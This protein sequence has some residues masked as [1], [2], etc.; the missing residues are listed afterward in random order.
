MCKHGGPPSRHD[1]QSRWRRSALSVLPGAALFGATS[2]VKR[3]VNRLPS[4]RAEP[5]PFRHRG[6]A[7]G[8]HGAPLHDRVHLPTYLQDVQP[9]PAQ[10]EPEEAVQPARCEEV[11]DGPMTEAQCPRI[12]PRLRQIAFPV[13]TLT[14][15]GTRGITAM[16]AKPGLF[17]VDGGVVER[18]CRHLHAPLSS[19]F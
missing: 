19:R 10:G 18:K 2:Q 13:V 9:H 8:N 17:R 7:T 15:G 16:Y 3:E 14:W 1:K 4:S 6:D 5:L 11:V 12:T